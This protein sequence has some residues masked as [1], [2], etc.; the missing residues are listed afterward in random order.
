[1]LE[2]LFL[3]QI[4]Y[5]AA[6]EAFTPELVGN[7]FSMLMRQDQKYF[8]TIEENQLE[9]FS[10][11]RRYNVG[12]REPIITNS[13]YTQEHLYFFSD[14][15]PS[16]SSESFERLDR[17]LR[18]E[19]VQLLLYYQ[20]RPLKLSHCYKAQP[21]VLTSTT[22]IQA[23]LERML[24]SVS[25]QRE[26][27]ISVNY[28]HYS[29]QIYH[30]FMNYTAITGIRNLGDDEG[31]SQLSVLDCPFGKCS[32]VYRDLRPKME[33]KISVKPCAH[34]ED[35]SICSSEVFNYSNKGV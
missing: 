29:H 23:P 24:L 5:K 17:M 25:E 20:E 3:Y 8:K 33:Y 22:H 30:R 16:A 21:L 11:N 13:C 14:I 19:E 34:F 2:K 6:S 28:L 7:V 35:L 27:S 15:C 4:D 32:L 31:F 26:T 18:S 1:M 10:A 12:A 9:K